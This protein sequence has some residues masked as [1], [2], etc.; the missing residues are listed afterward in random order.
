M[1]VATG[2]TDVPSAVW[3]N[4]SLDT[5]QCSMSISNSFYLQFALSAISCAGIAIIAG[6]VPL[7]IVKLSKSPCR[8]YITDDGALVTVTLSERT[9][10]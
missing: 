4:K 10:S 5:Q 7:L 8:G 9:T 1:I 6:D 3:E 2:T